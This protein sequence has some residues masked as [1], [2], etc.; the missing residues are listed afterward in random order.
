[1]KLDT[2]AIIGVG[3]IGGSIGLALRQ[4]AL[5]RTVVGIGRTASR[6]R[7]AEESGA[8]S[9][10]TT[11]VR[12]GVADA[13]LIV[14]CTP[15]GHIADHVQQVSR[16]CRADAL[17]TDAGST[18]GEICRAL[19]VGLAG[20]GVFVGS[21]PLAGSEKSG[22]EFADPNLFEGCVTVVT[23]AETASERRVAQVESFWQ[24]L[25]SRVLRMSPDEHDRAVAEISHLPHLLASA[26]AAAADPQ[27]L[28]LAARGWQDT[29]RLAAGDV[30]LWRQ[31]L[32]ENRRHVLQ[33]LDKF[34]KVLS[35]FRQALEGNDPAEL[36]RLLQL[37][38]SNR[39]SV[40][41]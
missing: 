36:V 10:V 3:L 26:L 2:V 39:D 8:V 7:V 19:A 6:L 20:G 25:G 11:D 38:K 34:G 30:E 29:T 14:V 18:K 40:A 4:R 12:Q 27:D 32:S 31:I 5:A 24:S 33:S 21:H 15:V 13:E 37:G 9:R 35:K 17:I 28:I 16:V 1:M 41:S 22:P 23:A